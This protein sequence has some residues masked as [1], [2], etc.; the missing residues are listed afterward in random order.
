MVLKRKIRGRSQITSRFWGGGGEVGFVE[1]FVT[2]QI[3][4]F[5]FFGK[6]VTRGGRVEKVVF[7]HDVICERPLIC[8]VP[9]RLS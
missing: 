7:L 2:V 6:F 3:Q 1:E 5:S 4:N 9:H 8:Q